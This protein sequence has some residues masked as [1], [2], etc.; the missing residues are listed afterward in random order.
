MRTTMIYV[1]LTDDDLGALVAE[2]TRPVDL[3]RQLRAG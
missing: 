3:K 1:H 2:G